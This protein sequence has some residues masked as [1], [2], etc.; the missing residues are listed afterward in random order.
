MLHLSC[1]FIADQS[2]KTTMELLQVFKDFA[3]S[4]SIHGLMFLVQPKL[5]KI[6]K[7]SWALIFLVAFIYAGRQ[8]NISFICKFEWFKYYFRAVCHGEGT[9]LE[10]VTRYL[11]L[12]K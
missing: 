9:V 12:Q 5:S 7:I 3:A 2:E 10:K 4:T 1:L 8:L 11:D 6:K